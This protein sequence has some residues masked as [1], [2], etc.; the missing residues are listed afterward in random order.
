[1]LLGLVA[2]LVNQVRP[3]ANLAWLVDASYA[4]GRVTLNL[5]GAS[6][7]PFRWVDSNFKPYCLTEQDDDGKVVK[8]V[9]LF[10]ESERRFYK[11]NLK[12][13]AEKTTKVWE[14]DVDPVL[15]YAYDRRLR[16][17]LLHRLEG[18]SWVPQVS[19]DVEHAFR[20]NWLSGRSKERILSSMLS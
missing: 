6:L 3:D 7:E 1:M 12:R 4:A 10:S 5:I 9:D 18:D 15:C 14:A 19:L 16:F 8:K 13:D 2:C 17:G 20:F 11:V